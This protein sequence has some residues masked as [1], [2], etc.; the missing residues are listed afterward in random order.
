MIQEEMERGRGKKREQERERR[1]V[2]TLQNQFDS[3]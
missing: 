2:H 1:E 3:V